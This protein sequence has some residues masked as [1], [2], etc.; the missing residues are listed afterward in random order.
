MPF[1][2]KYRLTSIFG[3]H[4]GQF[5]IDYDCHKVRHIALFHEWLPLQALFSI[6]DG[7]ECQ[8]NEGFYKRKCYAKLGDNLG[9]KPWTKCVSCE[10]NLALMYTY[11]FFQP[12]KT[13][14]SD[15]F[16]MEGRILYKC[17]KNESR[18]NSSKIVCSWK[19]FVTGPTVCMRSFI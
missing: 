16:E 18:Q 8:L 3:I 17:V 19:K 4:V 2:Q 14:F 11:V 5:P 12:Q 13:M 7:L 6:T 9:Y 10:Y 1:C 15:Y